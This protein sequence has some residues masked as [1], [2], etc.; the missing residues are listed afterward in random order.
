LPQQ[1]P[2][3]TL[4]TVAGQER[5]AIAPLYG[6]IFGVALQLVA[7]GIAFLTHVPLVG[8]MLFMIGIVCI[9]ACGE[10]LRES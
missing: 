1:S 3:A 4:E 10:A 2:A 9:G 7:S 5:R 8:L 6:L